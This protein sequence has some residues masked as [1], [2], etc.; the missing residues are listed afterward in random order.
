MLFATAVKQLR[1]L[2]ARFE[3]MTPLDEGHGRSLQRWI[4]VPIL[5]LMCSACAS[6]YSPPHGAP[7]ATLTLAASLSHHSGSMVLA[8]NFADTSCKANPA[9]TRLAT[10]TS[11]QL[12]GSAPHSG[13]D[14]PV[15]AGQPFVLS[16]YFTWGVAS[17]TGSRS[18]SVTQAFTPIAGQRYRAFFDVARDSCSLMI[19]RD[20]AGKLSAIP[21]LRQ[22]DPPCVD[23]FNG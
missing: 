20:D 1:A 21:D 9:G 2:R 11:L 6:F 17:I 4:C 13:V 10:F 7:V 14:V 15:A 19:A 12:K 22:V 8:Q 3:A 18:C 16:Y 5:A 23:L